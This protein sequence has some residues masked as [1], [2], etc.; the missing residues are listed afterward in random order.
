MEEW[1][2]II[3]DDGN[4]DFFDYSI[5]LINPIDVYCEGCKKYVTIT[6]DTFERINH[7]FHCGYCFQCEESNIH[8]I[9]E[10]LSKWDNLDYD[11]LECKK[12]N[13]TWD[14]G[15][16]LKVKIDLSGTHLYGLVSLLIVHKDISEYT[17]FKIHKPRVKYDLYVSQQK[18]DVDHLYETHS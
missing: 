14:D 12:Q 13:T 9:D 15:D 2:N 8:M 3:N 18:E 10:L 11:L 1:K 5:S 7:L 16:L 4:V 17:A 6:I